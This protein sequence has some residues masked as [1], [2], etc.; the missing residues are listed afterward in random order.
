M[1]KSTGRLLLL[2]ANCAGHQTLMFLGS[3]VDGLID[4]E[5]RNPVLNAVGL[6]QARVV[7]DIVDE[8]QR[9]PVGGTDQD[10]QQF[11][12]ERFV[13]GHRVRY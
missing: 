9:S 7:E 2:L 12:V 6:V 10:A 8:G 4:E 3:D 11:R 1:L 5:Y 13:I